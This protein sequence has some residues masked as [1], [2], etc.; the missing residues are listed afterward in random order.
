LGVGALLLLLAMRV[1]NLGVTGALAIA[2]LVGGIVVFL[3]A[4][5]W[6]LVELLRAISKMRDG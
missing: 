1:S 5:I 2:S 3:A 4:Q 6:F